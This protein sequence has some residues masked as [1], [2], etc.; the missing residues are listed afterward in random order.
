MQNDKIRGIELPEG[1]VILLYQ[2]ADDTTV[3]VRD[4]E[5][6]VEV[7]SSVELYG[8]ASGAKINIEKSEI[9]YVGVERAGRREIGLK[10]KK[11][12]FRML[13]VN[14]GIEDREGRDE[15]Y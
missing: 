3:T 14:L 5:S 4:R 11:D 13:G 9:M 1:Q 7:L 15:W 10:E 2:Y 6:V 12:Y 8:R